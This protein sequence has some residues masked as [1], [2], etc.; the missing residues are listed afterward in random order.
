MGSDDSK[1]KEVK[2]HKRNE[3]KGKAKI[4]S[5]LAFKILRIW[6]YTKWC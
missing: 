3:Q 2:R 6:P 5:L 4:T 1:T